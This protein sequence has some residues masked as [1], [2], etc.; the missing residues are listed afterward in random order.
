MPYLA[1]RWYEHGFM[2]SLGGT[3]L[4]DDAACAIGQCLLR[5]TH[6]EELW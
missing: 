4:G 5:N 1:Y 3:S 6:V 2:R